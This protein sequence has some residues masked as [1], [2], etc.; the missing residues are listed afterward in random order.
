MCGIAGQFS[1][2]HPVGPNVVRSMIQTLYHR[3]PDDEGIY[4]NKQNGWQGGHSPSVGLGHRRLSIIDLSTGH[5]PI[6]NEDESIWIVFNG[7]I[8]NFQLLKKDLVKNGHKYYTTTDTEVIIHL[9]EKYGDDCVKYLRGM[10]AFAIWDDKQKKLFIARDRLGKKPLYY[11]WDGNTLL[12]ASELKGILAWPGFKRNIDMKALVNY[13]QFGYI[14]D[15]LSIIKDVFKL[16]PGHLLTLKN[17]KLNIQKYWELNFTTKEVKNE[18]EVCEGLLEK[19]KESVKLRLISDV[20]LGAFLSGGIDSSTIVT[21]MAQEMSQPVKTFSIGFE[22]PEYNELPYARKVAG[23]LGTEHHEMIVRPESFDLIENIIYQFDEPFGD[24]SAIPTYYVSKLASEHVKVVLSGDGG[25]ELFAGYDSYAVM[26]NRNKYEILPDPVRAGIRVL[27]RT[28]PAGVYGK[29]F[30]YNISLP[31]DQRFIDYVSHVSFRKHRRLLSDDLLSLMKTNGNL[32][33]KHFRDA[34]NFDPLSRLQYVDMNLYLPGDILVK[35]DRMSMAHSLETR[36]PLLDQEVV[37]FVNGLPWKYKMNGS[38]RKYIFRKAVEKLL[39]REI[40]D[41]EKRG[42]AVPL[43]YWF[44][45]DLREYIS[46]I[47]F[48]P[49]TLQRDYF[50]KKY[51]KQLIT[52]LE[53]G[54]RDN[55]TLL[56]H[57]V[58]FELWHRNY[59]D[60]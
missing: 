11:Y 17:K 59:L 36:V 28:L 56:W 22:E 30:L 19:L 51:I 38:K 25:D 20:P 32:F 49:K 43:K 10:F 54:K 37:E 14:T 40:I 50:N 12:F 24:A 48:E 6:H 18:E 33:E 13:L 8:Y 35:V 16:P 42:F 27:S 5:Q 9:Y 26:M 29:N 60:K 21:L 7:E 2:T 31:L 44:K 34:A 4:L 57:L 15:P 1:Y 52:E 47:L 53:Q 3:G 45:E 46:L 39:P 55:S 23:R 58:V 41:R